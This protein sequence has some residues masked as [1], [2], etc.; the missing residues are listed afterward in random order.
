[1]LVPLK[2]LTSLVT[3]LMISGDVNALSFMNRLRLKAGGGSGL[4]EEVVGRYFDGVTKKDRDQIASCFGK[5][6]TIRDVCGLSTAE[7]SASCDDLADRCM[8]FLA[9]HPDCKVDFHY[10]PTCG[11]GSGSRWVFSHWYETGTWSG[12]SCGIEPKG[13]GTLMSPLCE[14]QT[15]FLVSDDLKIEEIVVTRTFTEWEK[16]L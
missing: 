5:V 7:R 3:L 2:G 12:T 9:A 8:D 6:A 15:R 13:D 16:M 4:R 1:M 10:P 14:G 11:R